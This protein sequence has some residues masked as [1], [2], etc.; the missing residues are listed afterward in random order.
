M[1]E[2]ILVGLL[3][4]QEK[5]QLTVSDTLA[6]VTQVRRTAFR[7]E[8][9]NP[10]TTQNEDRIIIEFDGVERPL[11]IP[12]R[13]EY[14]AN[15]SPTSTFLINGLN[16]ANLNSVYN[17]NATTGSLKQRTMHRLA[18][19]GESTQVCNRTLV[20]TLVGSPQ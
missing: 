7:I 10:N 16:T 1:F 15:T 9:D 2:L 18:V 20:G 17:N 5:I 11:L 6:T 3:L 13:C 8:D 14:N 12:V 19:M 4:E